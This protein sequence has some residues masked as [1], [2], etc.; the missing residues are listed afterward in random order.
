MAEPKQTKMLSQIKLQLSLTTCVLFH[1]LVWARSFKRLH[2]QASINQWLSHFFD[3]H[4]NIII[5]SDTFQP[6]YLEI[7]KL[8]KSSVH[9]SNHRSVPPSFIQLSHKSP[10]IECLLFF[11]LV[12]VSSFVCFTFV[13]FLSF[14]SFSFISTFQSHVNV[15]VRLMSY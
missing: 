8:K 12:V 14:F 6:V 9:S 11:D 13:S 4:E 5:F 10:P 3:N 2:S 7:W 15:L 1:A